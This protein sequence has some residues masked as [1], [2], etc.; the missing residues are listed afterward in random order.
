MWLI[1]RG[2]LSAAVRRLHSSYCLSSMTGIAT[3]L[4]ENQA[5]E[6]PQAVR[7]GHLRRMAAELACIARLPLRPAARPIASTSSCG[8]W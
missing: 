4:L 2:A 8:T 7:E 5:A 1:M 6:M 3:L